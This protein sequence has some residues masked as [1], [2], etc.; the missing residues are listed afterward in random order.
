[1]RFWLFVALALLTGGCS[2]QGVAQDANAPVK[3]LTSQMYVTIRN[4]SGAPLSELEVAIVPMGRQTV[5]NKFIGRL[6]NSE[7]RNVMLGDFLGRDG[8]PFSLRVVKPR[9]VGV[10]GKDVK[11]KDYST[12]VAW[13]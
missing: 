7:S 1:M 11:G 10:K 3:I 6:E 8:T 9:S 13:R 12:E 4:D 5:Y 2:E